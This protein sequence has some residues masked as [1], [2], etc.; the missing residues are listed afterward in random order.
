MT[1]IGRGFDM[2]V[3]PPLGVKPEEVLPLSAG[4]CLAAC[5]SGA[6]SIRKTTAG[7]EDGEL[8][9]DRDA[10]RKAAEEPVD[11]NIVCR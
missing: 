3:G 2:R 4:A 9:L 5:P 11:V 6:L 1:F 7:D 8:L 10:E